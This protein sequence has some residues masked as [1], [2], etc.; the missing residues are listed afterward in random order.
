MWRLLSNC[1][2]TWPC[3]YGDTLDA[4]WCAQLSIL[5]SALGESLSRALKRRTE[6]SV[7]LTRSS[8]HWNQRRK[9]LVSLL[10]KT[11]LGLRRARGE[12]VSVDRFGRKREYLIDRSISGTSRKRRAIGSPTKS[13]EDGVGMDG[14]GVGCSD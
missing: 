11:S 12:Q 5:I 2:H 3:L 9:T 4:R 6:T 7:L 10:R 13:R 8:A 1:S 14:H